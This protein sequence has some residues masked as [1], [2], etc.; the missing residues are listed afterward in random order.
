MIMKNSPEKFW[1]AGWKLII[2]NQ[3][4]TML[5]LFLTDPNRAGRTRICSEFHSIPFHYSIPSISSSIPFLPFPPPFRPFH[6]FRSS[7]CFHSELQISTLWDFQIIQILQFSSSWVYFI[8]SIS[9]WQPVHI[10][11]R[12]GDEFQWLGL[13]FRI[14]ILNVLESINA[15]NKGSGWIIYK[16]AT[17]LT[18]NQTDAGKLMKSAIYYIK[19]Q[20]SD[21]YSEFILLCLPVILLSL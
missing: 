15:T 8:F 9:D 1:V 17:Y 14:F 11:A 21:E 16:A 6:A 13:V 19:R 20:F 7:I 3:S 4:V 5:Y 12:Q 10:T 18:W 2:Q